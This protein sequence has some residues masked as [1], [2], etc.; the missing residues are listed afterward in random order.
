MEDGEDENVSVS[1][2]PFEFTQFRI[3]HRL[4]YDYFHILKEMLINLK[5][6]IIFIS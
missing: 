1:R 6:I 4:S 3:T 5:I 2:K